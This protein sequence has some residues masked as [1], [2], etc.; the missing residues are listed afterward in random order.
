M[1]TENLLNLVIGSVNWP[2]FYHVVYFVAAVKK[3]I[4]DEVEQKTQSE[5]PPG[6]LSNHDE[7]FIMWSS[8]A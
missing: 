4:E 7:Y 2:G 3:Y 1:M 6:S 8:R 5:N